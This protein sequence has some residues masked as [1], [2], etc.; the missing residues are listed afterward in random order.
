MLDTLRLVLAPASPRGSLVSLHSTGGGGML[1]WRGKV[2]NKRR[3]CHRHKSALCL[4]GTWMEYIA[5][6]VFKTEQ[7]NAKLATLAL[8]ASP[9][10]GAKSDSPVIGELV[11]FGGCKMTPLRQSLSS[12]KY[13]EQPTSLDGYLYKRRAQIAKLC[14]YRKFCN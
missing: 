9:K 8:G 12:R 5:T 10:K 1:A 3:H 6:K 14:Q 7:T 4:S 11:K 2:C 13:L